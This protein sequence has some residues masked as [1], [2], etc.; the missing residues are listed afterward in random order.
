MHCH[1]EQGEVDNE[2]W[3]TL[4]RCGQTIGGVYYN[5]L[6]GSDETTSGMQQPVLGTA[7]KCMLK[8][9]KSLKEAFLL[10]GRDFEERAFAE[11]LG[12]LAYSFWK[13]GVKG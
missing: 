13:R 5:P 9:G 10:L 2:L 8:N 12:E 3:H 7:F 6:H 11:G 4:G 1:Y